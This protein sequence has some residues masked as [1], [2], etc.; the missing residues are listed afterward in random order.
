M[1]AY[2]VWYCC[3]MS[4]SY[5]ITDIQIYETCNVELDIY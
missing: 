1:N 2:D 3:A 4:T 5:R